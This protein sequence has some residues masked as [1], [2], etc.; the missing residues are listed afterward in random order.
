MNLSKSD[1]RI[2]LLAIII[3]FCVPVATWAQ[4]HTVKGTVTDLIEGFSLPGVNILEVGTSNGTVTN[5]NGEFSI[6]VSRPDATLRFSYI[7]YNEE[8]VEVG[9]RTRI[10]I[11]MAPSIQMLTEMVVVGYGVQ[12]R[13]DLTGSVSV[14]TGEELTRTN[15]A[16]LGQALQGRA[17]GVSV[18]T[19]SGQPGSQTSIKIRGIGSISSGSEP[20]YV[21]DGM[22]VNNRFVIN[23]I[24]PADIESVSVL[25][26]ASATAIYGA[27]GANGV[28]VIKTRRGAKDQT[29]V[30]LSS[31]G[32]V[33]VSPGRYNLMNAKQY[34]TFMRQATE[35]FAARNA[36]YTMPVY[37]TDEARALNGAADTDWQNQIL[38]QGARQS[39]DVSI[40]GGASNFN[41]LFSANY[42]DETG[43]LV[44]T[45]YNRITSRFN[46]DLTAT[47]WLR[48]GQAFTFG[49]VVNHYPSHR[50]RNPWSTA[51]LAS[52]FM[53]VLNADKKGGF[54]GPVETITGPND[55]T[56]P[57][58]EQMLNDNQMRI[59]QLLATFYSEADIFRGLKY[60]ME[61]G[62]SNRQGVAMRFSPEYELARAWSNNSSQLT[63]ENVTT[64]NLLLN[65]LLSYENNFGGHNVNVLLGQSGERSDMRSFSVTGNNIAFDKRVMSLAQTI[66]SAGGIEIPERYASYFLRGMYDYRG[67]YLFTGTLR[68]DGSSKFGDQNRI[69]YFPSFSLGWKLNEDLLPNVE[70]IDMLKLRL[71]WGQ[72]GNDNI[73]NFLY[74]DR[75][76]NP[77]ETRYPFGVNETIHYGGTILRSFANPFVKWE[78]SEMSNFGID[79]WLFGARVELTAEYYYKNQSDMLIEMQQYHFFGRQQESGRMPVNIGEISNR[80]F[81][82]SMSYRNLEGDFN[83]GINLNATTINNRVDYLPGDEPIFGPGG[84][85]ITMVGHPIGSF[86]G[87]VVDGVFQMSDFQHNENGQP[88]LVQGNYVLNNGIPEH[89]RQT[90]PGDLKFRDISGDGRITSD[91][92]QIIGNPFP[93]AIFGANFDFSYQNFDLLLFWEGVYGNDIY[94]QVSSQIGLATEPLSQGW[95]RLISAGD[96]WTEENASTTMTR[97][98]LTDPNNNAR[99][100][101]WFIEDGSYI[102]LK[103]LQLGYRLPQQLLSTAGITNARVYVSAS[104]LLT[105]TRY[106]GLDPEIN[107]DNP[108]RSG[109]DLGNYPVPKSYMM[110]IQVSF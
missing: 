17:A 3:L 14:V 106:S 80:G 44:N 94:N 74:I 60:R 90:S 35:N 84:N 98:Y 50:G 63:Q 47:P 104:N 4:G 88:V 51:S 25:K 33:T 54:E 39:H 66:V 53:P 34:A 75:I 46:S 2:F 65:N 36:G 57:R 31:Y 38:Q 76:N 78:A 37:F 70:Q 79:A 64:V 27:R 5:V 56:N 100:S 52:P 29:E 8:L 110:G 82:L 40:R 95:N 7:G 55:Q 72:T 68:R 41:F 48:F 62:V 61:L 23:T 96:F 83:Y 1:L 86:Y 58:A 67:R 59:N 71:G 81:E 103:N 108:L 32:G 21:V 13:E 73:G 77:L 109:F 105:F 102:R 107:A 12:R 45:G 11:A 15:P 69:G 20:L 43:I 24:N 91:D 42:Y 49:Q 9:G 6:T 22:I 101:T 30:T 85:T 87:Y 16:T 19:S 97:A 92:M 18:T 28:V 10:D 89:S 26:D 93:K 99:M